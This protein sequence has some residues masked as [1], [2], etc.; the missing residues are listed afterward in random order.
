M[1]ENAQ[2]QI[3]SVFFLLPSEVFGA[4]KASYTVHAHIPE[5][6]AQISGFYATKK[7]TCLCLWVQLFPTSIHT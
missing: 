1:T 7:I 2:K 3:R 5:K 6:R 4:V